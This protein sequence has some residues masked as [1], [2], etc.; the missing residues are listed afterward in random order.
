A[1][2]SAAEPPVVRRGGTVPRRPA[3]SGA[4]APGCALHRC[5][6]DGV[7]WSSWSAIIRT[8]RSTSSWAR[9]TG[10]RIKA[11][12]HLRGAM[13]REPAGSEVLGVHPQLAQPGGQPLAAATLLLERRFG[14]LGPLAFRLGP[15]AFRL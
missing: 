15:L 6:S 12:V 8:A 1:L 14:N 7:N 10:H 2:V 3:A 5:A 11:R 4:C 9:A 13:R